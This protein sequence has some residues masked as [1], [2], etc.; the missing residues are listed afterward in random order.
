MSE[1]NEKIQDLEKYSIKGTFQLD[2]N[3][4]LRKVCNIPAKNDYSGIYLFYDDKRNL[5]YVGISG[6]EGTD[7]QII[8]RKDGLRGR[9]LTGKQFGEK[10]SKTLPIEMSREG[11]A[12]IEVKWFV[13]YG[14]INRDIPR[15]IEEFII[16]TYK[17][18]N[19]GL[20]PKWNKKD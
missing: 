6:R 11:Y 20:R 18:E 2:S 1:L 4:E 3:G 19:N 14:G 12:F 15:L 8:H 17:K 10:R 16:Q 13:T 9:F 7:G 5:I